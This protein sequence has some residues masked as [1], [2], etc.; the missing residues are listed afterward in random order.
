LGMPASTKCPPRVLVHWLVAAAF[1]G[2]TGGGGS[3]DDPPYAIRMI[4]GVDWLDGK[5]GYRPDL[6][7]FVLDG[8]IGTVALRATRP[9]ASERLVLLIRT[10]PAQRPNL[11]RFTLI[12]PARTFETSPFSPPAEVTVLENGKA[13]G[14][15]PVPAYFDFRIEGEFVRVTLLP[16]ATEMLQEEC[17]ISWI[18]WYRR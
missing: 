7:G 10:T 8:A 9:G 18:D 15:V 1:A 12:T 14:R 5:G 16:S 6:P 11:E 2:C 4:K 3:Q 17:R 13:A